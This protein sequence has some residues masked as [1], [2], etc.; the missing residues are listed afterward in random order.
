MKIC[1]LFYLFIQSNKYIKNEKINMIKKYYFKD[2]HNYVNNNKTL[3]ENYNIYK[4]ISGYDNRNIT[5]EDNLNK[6][7]RYNEINSMLQFLLSNISDI[8][9]VLFIESNDILKKN[10]IF[11]EDFDFFTPLHI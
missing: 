7:I 2:V 9:K 5:E 6:I 8:E 10:N 11:N 3:I 1:C 4:N